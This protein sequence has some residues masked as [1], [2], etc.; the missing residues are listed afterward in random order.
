MHMMLAVAMAQ[1][2]EAMCELMGIDASSLI[3]NDFMDILGE[4]AS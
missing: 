3:D 1:V 4:V 2:N